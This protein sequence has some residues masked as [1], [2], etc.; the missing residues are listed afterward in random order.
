[1]RR[2]VE[3][4]RTGETV[5]GTVGRRNGVGARRA[6]QRNAALTALL[7]A[8]LL[9]DP[10]HACQAVHVV[11]P[12]E[13][14]SLIAKQHY[15]DMGAF[16]K[17]F[18]E[19]ADVIGGNPNVIK[20]G[21]E[22][23]LPCVDGALPAIDRREA[24][25][26][27]AVAR[28]SPQGIRFKVPTR[29]SSLAAERS[30]AIIS[31]QMLRSA[32]RTGDD[33][34]PQIVD[35]AGQRSGAPHV[36]DGAISLPFEN[37]GAVAND[38]DAMALLLKA[39]ELDLSQRI[40]LVPG[41]DSY[42]G[43]GAAARVFW[44]LKDAGAEKIALLDAD[45]ESWPDA[46]LPVTRLVRVPLGLPA[47]IEAELEVGDG[48]TGSPDELTVVEAS[49]IDL[50]GG[51]TD[52]GD[53]APLPLSDLAVATV[54]NFKSLDLPWGHVPVHIEARDP[55]VAALA[56]FLLAEVAGI[57]EV[58]LLAPSID[59]TLLSA[60]DRVDGDV[61]HDGPQ[62]VPGTFSLARDPAAEPETTDKV[63]SIAALD[64]EP[65]TPDALAVGRPEPA[66]MPGLD[67]AL[68]GGSDGSSEIQVGSSTE[69]AVRATEPD[70]FLMNINPVPPADAGAARPPGLL[71]VPP[72]L[73]P[74]PEAGTE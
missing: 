15:G 64:S 2:R 74:K 61:A 5:N 39:A 14:L 69:P 57:D 50:A 54:G 47:P 23:R 31:A 60:R 45:R 38:E 19:N 70:S 1:M 3:T 12:G 41:E 10:A 35:L 27:T 49:V 22:L 37:W 34:T 43:M 58:H 18:Q 17:I 30:G 6:L 13:S 25:A 59:G 73:E 67:A 7:S 33:G 51:E 32:L 72:R 62:L 40:V 48:R 20:A 66:E 36:I 29:G 21:M 16:R 55:N 52:A 65:P 42:E 44:A 53:A 11:K 26:E 24:K 56:W 46:G 8:T 68:P 9:A 63:P 71:A 28:S 4:D